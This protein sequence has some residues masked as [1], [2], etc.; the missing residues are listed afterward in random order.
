MCTWTKF[1]KNSKAG[2]K[3][4]LLSLPA[5]KSTQLVRDYLKAIDPSA[6]Q[7][8]QARA[9]LADDFKMEDPLVSADSADDFI[10]KIRS[11]GSSPHMKS[12]IDQLIGDGDIV[13]ALTRLEVADQ[14]ITY[15]QWFWL[16]EGKIKRHRTV[17][18][19]R[20]FL[21]MAGQQ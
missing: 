19:P 20:P 11:Y 3:K 10:A 7:F 17:Y 15:A 5:M 9:L 12:S 16:S 18:D 21:E 8:E 14:T 1:R 4:N 13:A 6:L 2:P